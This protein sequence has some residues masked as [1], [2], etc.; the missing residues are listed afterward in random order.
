MASAPKTAGFHLATSQGKGG[1]IGRAPLIRDSRQFLTWT[2]SRPAKPVSQ[3]MQETQDRIKR[4][5]PLAALGRRVANARHDTD[6]YRLGGGPVV[7]VGR[8]NTRFGKVVNKQTGKREYNRGRNLRAPLV[9]VD[10]PTAGFTK[11][12]DGRILT[13]RVGRAPIDRSRRP[14][15]STPQRQLPGYATWANTSQ[16]RETR[17]PVNRPFGAPSET[18]PPIGLRVNGR[19]VS[20]PAYADWKNS[21]LEYNSALSRQQLLQP[22]NPVLQGERDNPEFPGIR[23]TSQTPTERYPA[24]ITK[25]YVTRGGQNS[26][27]PLAEDL[28]T[29]HT[30]NPYLQVA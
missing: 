24:P 17:S 28:H 29:I 4:T 16:T 26:P 22:N 8:D 19:T 12:P 7:V 30:I 11:G 21:H 2:G 27:T 9:A 25:S 13:D 23:A 14:A 6:M 3:V 5:R 20:N 18:S 1:R 10:R 15:G